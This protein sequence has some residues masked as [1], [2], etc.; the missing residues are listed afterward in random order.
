MPLDT[1]TVEFKLKKPLD[2]FPV[3]LVMGIVQAGSAPPTR[4]RP[5]GTGPYRLKE[6]VPDDRCLAGR[7]R[8]VLRRHVRVTTAW[9]CE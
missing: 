6:F 4:A 7:L 1:Y 3:N 8:S 5:I 2:S 9:C